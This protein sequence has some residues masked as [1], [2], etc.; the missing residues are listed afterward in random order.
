V[1]GDV[2]PA[3]RCHCHDAKPTAGKAADGAERRSWL[4][5]LL[6]K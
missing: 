1:L 3:D 4:S 2:P 5:K 6:S